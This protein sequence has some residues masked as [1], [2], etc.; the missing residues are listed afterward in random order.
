MEWNNILASAQTHYTF[1]CCLPSHVCRKICSDLFT[2]DQR[3]LNFVSPLQLYSF[4]VWRHIP[5]TICLKW[6]ICS[7][8]LYGFLQV[9]SRTYIYRV[10]GTKCI[11]SVLHSLCVHIFLYVGLKSGFFLK[12]YYYVY[13]MSLGNFACH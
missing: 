9:V 13:K 5:V 2:I 7:V 1:R 4:Y 8:R 6:T 10:Q 11:L 3:T 12:F